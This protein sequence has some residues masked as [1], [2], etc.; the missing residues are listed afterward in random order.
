MFFNK[1]IRSNAAIDKWSC[2]VMFVTLL[3]SVGVSIYA[4]KLPFNYLYIVANVMLFVLT[5]DALRDSRM[6]KGSHWN[7]LEYYIHDLNLIKGSVFGS[8]NITRTFIYY[9]LIAV[10]IYEIFRSDIDGILF[11]LYLGACFI[12]LSFFNKY[13]MNDVEVNPEILD[14]I[15]AIENITDEDRKNLENDIYS[16]IKYFKRLYRGELYLIFE[17]H[18][19]KIKEREKA[20]K[21]NELNS[22]KDKYEDFLNRVEDRISKQQ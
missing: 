8:K 21:E 2:F 11:I 20:L 13:G 3:L 10:L 9:V 14:R 1:R 4:F 19:N 6:Y 15:S 17:K 18:L 5:F 22:K 16:H 7:T 12:Y